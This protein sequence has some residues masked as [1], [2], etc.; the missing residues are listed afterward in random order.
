MKMQSTNL[1]SQ[2]SKATV[3]NLTTEVKE[4]LAFGYSNSQNKTFS[5]AELWNIQRQ[6]RSL[7]SRR[8]FAF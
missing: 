7:G 6:R 3:K 4:T 2:I 1:F 5:A 8:G